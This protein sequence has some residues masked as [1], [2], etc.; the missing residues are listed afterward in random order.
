VLRRLER[1]V[2]RRV[3]SVAELA[4]SLA[5]FASA[6]GQRSLEWIV[7]ATDRP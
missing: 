1:D 7:N 6:R 2:S 5:P 3:Q 4:R